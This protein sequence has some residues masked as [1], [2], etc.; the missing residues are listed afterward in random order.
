MAVQVE[1][2]GIAFYSGC[3][4]ARASTELADLFR[5]L[6]EQE[7]LHVKVFTQM[8]Q[9]LSEY[10][11][12]ESYPGETE[13]YI[14]TFVSDRVFPADGDEM[15][16]PEQITDVT[17]AIETALGMEKRSILLYSGIRDLVRES[18]QGVMDGIIA[19][20]REHIRRLLSLRRSLVSS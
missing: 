11:L 16:S 13:S 20:E 17:D 12:P 5:Y 4:A 14:A 18:E 19:E 6:V 3:A 8:K 7:K 10:T 2:D 9:G 1:E 15:C